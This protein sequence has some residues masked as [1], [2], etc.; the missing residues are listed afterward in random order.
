[1]SNTIINLLTDK[2]LAS[3][4][5]VKY[6]TWSKQSIPFTTYYR[7]EMLARTMDVKEL[8]RKS[9]SFLTLRSQNQRLYQDLGS[10]RLSD[11]G[12]RSVIVSDSRLLVTW[13]HNPQSVVLALLSNQPSFN[14]FVNSQV[15]GA[16]LSSRYSIGYL[17][18]VYYQYLDEI[19]TS[20]YLYAAA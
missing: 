6:C 10:Y 12:E 20:D 16:D 17:S 19:T 3:D 14:A 4:V 2:T 13:L 15:R 8:V 5:V 1:M 18:N 11:S 9:N 7:G